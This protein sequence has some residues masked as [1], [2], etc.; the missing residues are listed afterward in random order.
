MKVIKRVFFT[1]ILFLL[2]VFNALADGPP[3]PSPTGK[4]ALP[5]PPG[6]P[7]N[8]NIFVI[9]IIAAL[10]GIYIIYSFKLKAKTPI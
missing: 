6:L 8:E 3:V 10:F 1:I 4:K 2:G 7:I 9:L 5:P